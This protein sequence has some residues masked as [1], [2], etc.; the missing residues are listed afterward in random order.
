[1]ILKYFIS[2]K[3]Y[4]WEGGHKLGDSEKIH[5]RFG[6]E[7]FFGKGWIMARKKKGKTTLAK[8]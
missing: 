1:M 7:R 5:K 8:I 4:C 3:R 6:K 2:K